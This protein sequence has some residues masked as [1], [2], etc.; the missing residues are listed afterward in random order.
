MACTILFTQVL[1]K[2][3]IMEIGIYE[4]CSKKFQN[5]EWI[6]TKLELKNCTQY[7]QIFQFHSYG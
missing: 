7:C 5:I 6:Q 2:R 3:F 4:K 1:D